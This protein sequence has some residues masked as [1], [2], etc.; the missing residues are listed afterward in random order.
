MI[1]C[2]VW[3][4]S[5]ALRLSRR[6]SGKVDHD[7]LICDFFF[8]FCSLPWLLF[9]SFLYNWK[10]VNCS[11]FSVCT[12]MQC[13]G[14]GRILVNGILYYLLSFAGEIKPSWCQPWFSYLSVTILSFL[15]LFSLPFYWT[16]TS[17]LIKMTKDLEKQ[18]VRIFYRLS[19]VISMLNKI[20]YVASALDV[21][22]TEVYLVKK[23]EKGNCITRASTWM[24][25]M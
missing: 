8:S 16:V 5:V 9:L 21:F 4:I 13:E 20:G 3:F 22:M 11:A 6:G 17:H 23:S 1:K 7:I 2:D 14:T 10:F 18:F 24:W 25:A 12:G 19:N 15:F